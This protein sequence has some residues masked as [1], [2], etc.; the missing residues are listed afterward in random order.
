MWNKFSYDAIVF[1]VSFK[2]ISKLIY[3]LYTWMWRYIKINFRTFFFDLVFMFYSYICLRLRIIGHQRAFYFSTYCCCRCSVLLT[4]SLMGLTSFMFC[5]YSFYVLKKNKRKK[6][7]IYVFISSNE[8]VLNVSLSPS[9]HL[10]LSLALSL[11]RFFLL[12]SNDKYLFE[13]LQFG[14]KSVILISNTNCQKINS[15]I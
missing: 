7:V 5:I 12:L 8:L 1:I 9:L 14:D 3:L 13:H 15:E 10:T 11:V 6:T 4:D 2:N